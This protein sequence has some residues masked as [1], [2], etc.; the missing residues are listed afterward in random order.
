MSA[1]NKRAI[2]DAMEF[3]ADGVVLDDLEQNLQMELDLK[4]EDLNFLM[5]ERE[6]INNPDHLGET[7][8]NVIWEQVM[9]QI[10]AVAADDFIEANGGQTLD[11]RNEAHILTVE[12]F[13]QGKM[14]THNPNK[15]KYQQRYREYRDDF[16]TDPDAEV[17]MSSN[18]RYNEETKTYERYDKGKGSWVG[19]TRYNEETKVWEDWDSRSGSWKKKLAAEA[20]N[21]FD[22]RTAAQKGSAS[23]AKDH[24]ISAAEQIR[25]TEAA[26]YVDRE[27]RQ[28]F[29]KSD[30][31]LND[32]D[33]RANS[34]KND[35]T[36]EEWLNS[37]RD[38]KKPSERFDIDEDDLR[39]KDVQARKE[40]EK[41]K[42]EGKKKT[43]DEGRKSQREE[44][45]RIGGQ[46][47]RMAFMTLLASLLKEII[48]K[49]V[50]W[51]KS[52]E[53][54]LNTLIEYIKIAIIAFVA[55]LKN[56]LVSTTESVLTMIVTSIVGPV[57]GTIK[58]TVAL[59]RQG[60]NS[61]KKAIEFLGAPENRGKPLS[62]LLPEVGK[63]V[64][65]GLSGIG[66][67][68]LGEFIE[69]ALIGIPL[70]AVDIP[71]LGSPA[72]LIGM[73]MGAVVCGVIGAIAINLINKFVA[74]QQEQD[75]LI[76]TIEKQHEVL[77]VQQGLISVQ[78]GQLNRAE[79][80]ASQSISARHRE[81]DAIIQESLDKIMDSS[82]S[83]KQKMNDDELECLLQDL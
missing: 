69:K 63:I 35:S 23:V 3:D 12:N 61:L 32:L 4:L 48:G 74:T 11:M 47:L 21:K 45:F 54:S 70:L 79:Q 51:L 10:P 46:A 31:N 17:K 30:V 78:I 58:K 50:Q 81:A 73:L 38:G 82:I 59:L 39:K 13:E 83:E 53:K 55:K 20:R 57:V 67:V 26:A 71:L 1:E 62:Y 33:A 40:Y 9:T 60:W 80:K 68:V 2:L 14:P 24:T 19:K 5:Q 52:A 65:A 64:I 29:A 28:N 72:N 8:L 6:H 44:A 7:V 37:E 22:T 18:M 42:A 36:M 15:E 77:E 49:L 76:S 43:I 66:A 27:T 75:N 16:Q 34:S 25:D 41:M 56:L